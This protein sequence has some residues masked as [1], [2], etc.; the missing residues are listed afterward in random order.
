MIVTVGLIAV[1]TA[2]FASELAFDA[3]DTAYWRRWLGW[4]GYTWRRVLL[5]LVP[6]LLAVLLAQAV[7]GEGDL[8]Q[9][10]WK[11]LAAGALAAAVLRADTRARVRGVQDADSAQA[12]SV[13]SWIYRQA[14]QRFDARAS[15]RI[16]AFV[17]SLRNAGTNYPQHLLMT[18]E[19]IAGVLSQE[20]DTAQTTRSIKRW[21]ACQDRLRE[22][23]D[24]IRDPFA[25]DHD[26]RRAAA[27]LSESII[28]ELAQRRWNRPPAHKEPKERR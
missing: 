28:N 5:A 21:K 25:D 12:A 3:G 27:A 6:V 4:F 22:Q 20:I 18:A 23:M 15:Q 7:S 17:T 16:V 9:Q 14:C 1:G 11:G 26:R 13:L 10:I 19:E 24:L 8:A 2:V